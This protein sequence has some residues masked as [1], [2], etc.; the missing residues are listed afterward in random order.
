MKNPVARWIQGGLGDTMFGGA[1]DGRHLYWGLQSGGIIS[2]DLATG[3][4]QWWA[5]WNATPDI[6]RHPGVSGAVALI[7]GVIFAGGMDGRM[8]AVA[9]FDGRTLGDFDTNK[10]FQTVNGRHNRRSGPCCRR[11]H[12]FCRLRVPGLQGGMP[13]N[14]LLAFAL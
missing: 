6:Y 11:Q 2:V 5:G 14:V 3:V 9:S 12:D 4:E 8:R 13:G 1:V 7:P 10:D